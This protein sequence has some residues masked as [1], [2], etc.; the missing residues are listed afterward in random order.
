MRRGFLLVTFLLFFFAHQARADYK[1]IVR[2]DAGLKTIQ[3]IC[4]QL[5]CRVVRGLDGGFG[6]VF[7]ISVPDWINP[8]TFLQALQLQNGIAD[9]ELDIRVKIPQPVINNF[10][11]PEL[12]DSQPVN[13]FGAPV[14]NG[15]A[16]Q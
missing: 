10:S 11:V 5:L 1:V 12:S 3:P 9:A 2:A 6:Q 14:W 13:Y 15:Y 4:V 16:N 7:L 8:D